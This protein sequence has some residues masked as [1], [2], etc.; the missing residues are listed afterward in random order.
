MDAI[1]GLSEHVARTG[2]RDLPSAAVGAT[3]AFLQDTIGVGVAGSAGPWVDD[4]VGCLR[5][6]GAADQATVW[7]RGTRFPAPATALANAYQIHNSEFDCVHEVAVVHPMTG[8]LS[9][10]LA[11]AERRGGVGGEELI[12][13]VALGVDV[14]CHIGAA[15]RAPLKFFR[16]GTAGGFGATAA[17]G[18]LMGFD[19]A[20][21]VRAMGVVYSQMCGTM[22]AH[23]EG[24]ILLGLQ[25]GFNARNA[26]V[27]CDM[28]GRAV[29]S[30]EHVLEGPFGYYRLF[31]GDYDVE[32]ILSALGRV[33]R[34]TEVSQKPFPSG[35]AT[36]GIVDGLLELQRR[37][38]FAAREVE[39]VTATVP[40]LV[41]QL[42]SRPITDRPEPSYA[43]LCAAYVGARALM[44]GTVG[45]EDFRTPAL[46][47][48]ATHALARRFEVDA[49]GNP[50][51]NALG[52]VTVA[53][54]LSNGQGHEVQVDRMY[55]SPA[56][57]MSRD[58]HLAKFRHN[59]VNG[60]RRLDETK[61]EGL[62][63]LIDNLEAVSDV[64]ELVGLTWVQGA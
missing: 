4:L 32:T 53:V 54:T 62:L 52:P 55:G 27:A 45:L 10:A 63:R 17:V 9:A 44:R 56:K 2:Y 60:A 31:E 33:W 16:P 61:G 19:A 42:V 49:D 13:A 40:P 5:G 47:D 34:I 48:P 23:I 43:R 15:S 8:V 14:A 59:W 28:A 12:A 6:W 37:I 46:T 20:T 64:R 57:P 24:S 30:L 18:K 41:H 51:P 1:R 38:G 58:A 21:M 36:H 3:K 39:W 25:I 50:D 29:P 22:Q 26:L 35:R 11:Y 7:V